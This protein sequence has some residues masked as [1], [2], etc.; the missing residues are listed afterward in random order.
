[1]ATS[2]RILRLEAS[3]VVIRCGIGLGDVEGFSGTVDFSVTVGQGDEVIVGV[4]LMEGIWGE[5]GVW[6]GFLE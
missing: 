1:M 4:V 5:W 3:Y 6:I 2:F